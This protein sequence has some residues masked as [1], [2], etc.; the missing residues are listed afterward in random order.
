MVQARK[1]VSVRATERVRVRVRVRVSE[2]AGI[3]F[4]GVLQKCPQKNEI[5]RFGEFG[6]FLEKTFAEQKKSICPGV[7]PQM[8][9]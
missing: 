4:F 2:R 8:E 6:L 9:E 1:G 5:R 7:S 3:L